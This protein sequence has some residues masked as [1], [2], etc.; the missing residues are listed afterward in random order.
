MTRVEALDDE[1][2]RMVSLAGGIYH[3]QGEFKSVLATLG[4]SSSAVCPLAAS[5]RVATARSPTRWA[6]GYSPLE[7][8][9]AAMQAADVGVWPV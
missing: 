9:V 3:F 4:L 6:L 5:C 8:F 2:M 1:Q 7:D